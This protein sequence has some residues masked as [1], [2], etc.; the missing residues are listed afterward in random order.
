VRKRADAAARV[1]EKRI[2]ERPPAPWDPFPL[3]ELAVFAGLV[4]LIIGIFLH[5]QLGKGLI[6]AG[7]TLACIGGLETAL[8]EHF[9]G[10]RA[11][12]GLLAG[13]AAVL[14]LA[15]VATVLG[16]GLVVRAAVAVGVF[17]IVFPALRSAFLRRSGGRGVL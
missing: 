6:A 12:S 7:V 14:S 2:A 17:A 15:I 5:G 3:T 4:L 9:G 10:Y 13:I 16:A 1:A 8:R 11:H